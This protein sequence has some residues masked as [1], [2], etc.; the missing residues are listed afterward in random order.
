MMLRLGGHFLLVGLALSFI[1]WPCLTSCCGT[2]ASFS[3]DGQSGDPDG[4]SVLE[5]GAPRKSPSA[6]AR[7]PDRD[8]QHP[9]ECPDC[10]M[11]GRRRAFLR[12]VHSRV[13]AAESE[14]IR[15]AELG[16]TSGLITM[17]LLVGPAGEVDVYESRC[18]EGAS[19]A[20]ECAV[21]VVSRWRFSPDMVGLCQVVDV[22]ASRIQ[23]MLG[24]P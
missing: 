16:R 18:E 19:S 15:C 8:I 1:C 5:A 24:N 11:D 22:P 3:T 7:V 21:T 17:Q 14:F 6:G 12:E 23:I 10:D 4:S 2:D 20:C 13:R 9:I